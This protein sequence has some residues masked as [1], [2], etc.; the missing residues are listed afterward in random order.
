[1]VGVQLICQ[2]FRVRL[3]FSRADAG[4]SNHYSPSDSL[5]MGVRVE[6]DG[7]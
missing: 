3:V 4:E 7:T 5:V 1:M 2:S 6:V